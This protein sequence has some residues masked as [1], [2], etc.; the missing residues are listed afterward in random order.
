MYYQNLKRLLV[1][2]RYLGVT[3]YPSEINALGQ[4]VSNRQLL[5]SSRRTRQQLYYLLLS[6]Y[7]ECQQCCCTAT[8][9]LMTNDKIV[10]QMSTTEVKHGISTSTNNINGMLSSLSIRGRGASRSSCYANRGTTVDTTI[11]LSPKKRYTNRGKIDYGLSDD[12]TSLYRR[13]AVAKQLCSSH[14]GGRSIQSENIIKQLCLQRNDDT[15][16]KQQSYG[17]T[18]ENEN[19]KLPALA[20]DD[21]KVFSTNLYIATVQNQLCGLAKTPILHHQQRANYTKDC[22]T[23][24]LDDLGVAPRDRMGLWGTADDDIPGKICG[25]ERLR[26]KRYNKGLGFDFTERQLLGIHG[27]LPCVYEDDEK[28]IKRCITLLDSFDKPLHKFMYL[29]N[30][31]ENNERLFYKVFASDIPKMLPLVY[32]PLVGL[33]CQKFSLIY[34]HHKGLFI[35]IKDKGHIYDVLK[36]YS[37]NNIRAIVVTNG[38]RILGLGDLGA[39]GMGISIGKLCL[40]VGLGGFKPEHCLPITLDVG[41]NNES[42]LKDPLYIG[43]RQKRA[44]CE[45]FEEFLEEFMQA[46][47]RRYGQNCLIQFEDFGN[48]NA[49][50]LLNKYRDHYCTFNDDIQGTGCAGIAGLLASKRIKGDK[51]SGKKF[52]FYGA[53]EACL[54]VANLL[55]KVLIEEGLS[56][57]EAKKFI[58]LFDSK[59]LIVKDRPSGGLTEHKEIFAQDHGPID[60][61]LDAVKTIKPAVLIG[62]AAIP[63]AFSDEILS[64]MG[65][66]NETPIIFALSNPTQKAEC[67]AEQAYTATKGKCLFASGSPFPPVDYNGQTYHTGQCNNSYC[68]PGIALGVVCSGMLTIPDDIFY[69]AAQKLADLCDLEQDLKVGRLYP[70]LDKI[71]TTSLEIATHIMAY[72]FDN[73]LATLHPEPENKREFIMN[74][75]YNLDYPPA[76]PKTYNITKKSAKYK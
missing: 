67:T 43:L 1:V 21:L 29:Y 73:C 13:N 72:A 39:N 35:S 44:K 10:A 28:Q 69:I 55:V 71:T 75:M 40:Y 18:N 37:E 23:D 56:E 65:E 60:K 16:K 46:V 11:R 8:L 52:L 3:I 48:T 24:Q 36:N 31:S 9:Q 20:S 19:S 64:L 14:S 58:W 25:I 53:G 61:L 47:V 32:T 12:K 33:A 41:T 66:Y 45:D 74:Q 63:G 4:I 62:G 59:G 17:R 50:G 76:V 57:D 6:K 27:L 68:F 22:D 15:I 7:N 49:F 70:P 42:L 5:V 34:T 30:L 38:E 26:N 51:L 54:G 2:R